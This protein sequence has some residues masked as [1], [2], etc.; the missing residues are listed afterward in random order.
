MFLT[1]SELEQLTGYLQ[2]KRQ[3]DVLRKMGI[4]FHMPGRR[5]V[6]TWEAVNGRERRKPEPF[7]FDKVM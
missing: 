1:D 5:P 7:R 4:P 3:A 2:G 6:V